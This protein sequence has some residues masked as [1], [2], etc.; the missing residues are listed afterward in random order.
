MKALVWKNEEGLKLMERP[1]PQIVNSCDIKIRVIYSGICGSD[2][3]VIK[4]NQQIVSDIIIGHEAVGEIIEV[5][6]KVTDY[7][8]GEKVIID[9]NQYCCDCYYCRKGLTNF[10]ESGD[11][12]QIAG[13]NIDGTFAEYFVC[14][15]RYV[16]KIPESMSLKE[17]VLIEPLACVINNI[18]AAKI[19]EDD[20]VL[21]LGS[22]PMGALC[23]MVAKR[24]ARFVVA[25]ENSK[26]RRDV[27]KGFNDIILDSSE[28]TIEKVNE[29]TNN[30][31][32]D[33]IIDTVGNQMEYA[34][35]IAGKNAR[36]IPMGMNRKYNFALSP[37]ILI[38]KG[39]QLIGASE[40]NM[41]FIDTIAAARR[42]NELSKLITAEYSVDDYVSAFESILGSTL[43]LSEKKDIINQK[44]VFSF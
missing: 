35:T 23:Q 36:I 42:Y 43:D 27:C 22:G 26:Y 12:L 38:D 15:Q 19:K 44:V 1:E 13:I 16:Y 25:T 29:L 10:C 39:I 14:N 20:N 32:F 40:Y 11:G 21:V 41:L 18:R 33:V 5:G 3:Q 31:K 30:R 2:L 6:E 7:K 34:L 37:Y 28:L 8:I 4:K 9:P 17:A 24:K